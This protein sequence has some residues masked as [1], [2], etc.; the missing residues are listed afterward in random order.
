V[1]PRLISALPVS[2][3]KGLS[4]LTTF[5]LKQAAL[6]LSL[7]PF[8][9]GVLLVFHLTGLDCGK[10]VSENLALRNLRLSATA[11]T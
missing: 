6:L 8:T 5:A 4:G 2:P 1:S 7:T 3:Y 10:M 9:L 11:A